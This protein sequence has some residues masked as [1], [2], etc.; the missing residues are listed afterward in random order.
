MAAEDEKIHH[1]DTESTDP[2]VEA[3]SRS[4]APCFPFKDLRALRVSVVNS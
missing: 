1:G 4:L 2:G 3:R